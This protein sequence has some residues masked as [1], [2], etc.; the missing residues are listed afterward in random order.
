MKECDAEKNNST[1]F[2]TDLNSENILTELINYLQDSKTEFKVSGNASKI[3]YTKIREKSEDDEE[4]KEESK[5]EEGDVAI[6]E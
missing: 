1:S 3:T 4:S 2:F 5:Q 6:K